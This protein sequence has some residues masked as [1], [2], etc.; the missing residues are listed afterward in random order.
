MPL[1]LPPHTTHFLQPL[2][3]GCFGPLGN[4]YKKELEVRNAVGEVHINKLDYL[5]FLKKARLNTMTQNIIMSAWAATGE[6]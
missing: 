4:A 5:G 3:V 1:C 6:N 2:D